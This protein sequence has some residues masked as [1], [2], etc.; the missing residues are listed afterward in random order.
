[1]SLMSKHLF[2]EGALQDIGSFNQQ[3]KY[4]LVKIFWPQLE[5]VLEYEY[6]EL[7]KF[8]NETLLEYRPHAK[9]FAFENF[10][11]LSD[12]MKFLRSRQASTRDEIA[13][14]LKSTTFGNC[15][16]EQIIKS[17]E[18]TV[19]LWLGLN[20]PLSGPFVGVVHPRRGCLRQWKGDETLNGMVDSCF[21]K[22]TNAVY[23]EFELDD[24]SAANLERVCLLHIEWTNC[25]NDHL[26]LTGNRGKRTLFLYQQKSTLINHEKIGS[27]IPPGVLDETIRSLDLLL[28]TGDSETRRLLTKAGKLSLLPKARSSKHPDSNLDEFDYW[29]PRLRRLLNLL[30]GAPE[31]FLQRLFDTRD[32]GQWAAL[33][34][35]ICGILILTLLFGILTTVYAIKQYF[36]AIESYNISIKSYELSL[37][38]AC[39]QSATQLPGLCG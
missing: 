35:G 18:L 21:E 34:V 29:K 36:V 19:R 26:R 6:G 7:F 4:E 31:S 20:I 30:H 38:L 9:H 12:T 24:L 14:E 15:S 10:Q 33:W 28:P 22:T 5:K 2:P 8:I 1:M 32:I 11:G 25:L 37:A 16:D 39:Q 13:A 17:M 27:P 23:T 3:Q